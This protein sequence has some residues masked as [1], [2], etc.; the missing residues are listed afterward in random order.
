MLNKNCQQ[1]C[2]CYVTDMCRVRECKGAVDETS[3]E[4]GAWSSL[5]FAFD[6]EADEGTWVLRYRVLQSL[7]QT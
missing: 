6:L 5:A 2:V 1:T 7:H 4:L 3:L